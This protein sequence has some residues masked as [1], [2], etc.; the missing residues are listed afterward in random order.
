MQVVFAVH[1]VAADLSIRGVSSVLWWTRAESLVLH[2]AADRLISAERETAR[3]Q[4]L[5][6]SNDRI[7]D[8]SEF[9]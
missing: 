5:L 1:F 8:T 4:T 6:G 2:H 9:L 3:I 7:L